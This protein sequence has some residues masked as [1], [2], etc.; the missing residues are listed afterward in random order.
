MTND[1]FTRLSNIFLNDIQSVQYDLDTV[2]Q[3][4]TTFTNTIDVGT[5]T[6]FVTIPSDQNGT[7]NNFRVIGTTGITY[8][9]RN[10][11][12]TK[13]QDQLVVDIPFNFIQG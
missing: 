10:I 9:E 5:L 12:F 13:T 4:N 11:T 2:T 7:F 3:T 6:L 8:T 1:G